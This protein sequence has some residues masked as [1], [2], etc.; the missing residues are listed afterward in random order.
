[1]KTRLYL[2]DKFGD[3]ATKEFE[4]ELD[5]SVQFAI[6]KQ[7]ED[8]SNPTLIINDWSKT[9][10]I[11]FTKHNNEVF[12]YIYKAD[13]IVE[14]DAPIGTFNFDASKKVQ[15]RLTHNENIVMTGYMK[16]LSVEQ[17]SSVSG[18]YNVTLNGEMGRIFQEMKKLTFDN[19]EVPIDIHITGDVLTIQDDG[20]DAENQHLLKI[21][22]TVEEKIISPNT[23]IRLHGADILYIIKW[24]ETNYTTAFN[25]QTSIIKIWANEDL[26]LTD[27]TTWKSEYPLNPLDQFSIQENK[28]RPKFYR[29]MKGRSGFE[30][31]FTTNKIEGATQI[32]YDG[33]LK[34]TIPDGD[35]Y[36]WY[37]FTIETDIIDIPLQ[38]RLNGA[39]QYFQIKNNNI[40]VF[41]KNDETL[42]FPNDILASIDILDSPLYYS[43]SSD[44]KYYSTFDTNE[45]I[46]RLKRNNDYRLD[47]IS[48]DNLSK[49][50]KSRYYHYYIDGEKYL[51]QYLNADFVEKCMSEGEVKMD[52]DA[53]MQVTDIFGFTLNNAFN[54]NF[55]YKSAIKDGYIQKLSEI[56]NNSPNKPVEA[57][58][59]TIIGNGITPLG[60][61]QQFRSYQQLPF[62]YFDKLFQIFKLESERILVDEGWKFDLDSD[63]FTTRNPFYFQYAFML[64]PFGTSKDRE[65]TELKTYEVKETIDIYIAPITVTDAIPDD[66]YK[67]DHFNVS[68]KKIY[69]TKHNIY[70]T[71]DLY[72]DF[73][74]LY[75]DVPD[76]LEIRDVL[77]QCIPVTIRVRNKNNEY[78]ESLDVKY[79]CVPK[80]YSDNDFIYTRHQ[81]CQRYDVGNE[82]KYIRGNYDLSERSIHKHQVNNLNELEPYEWTKYGTGFDAV[83]RIR[84]DIEL[85]NVETIFTSEVFNTDGV[86]ELNKQLKQYDVVFSGQYLENSFRN[87]SFNNVVIGGSPIG[88]AIRPIPLPYYT[89]K[90]QSRL[91]FEIFRNKN[92]NTFVT[93]NDF[94]NNEY[95][96]FNV[97][98][99]YCKMFRILIDVDYIQK[100]IK[101]MPTYKFFQSGKIIDWSGKVD[102]SK[103]WKLQPVIIDSNKLLFNYD[104]AKTSLGQKY[105]S[106][107]GYNSG[108]KI[109]NTDYAFNNDTKKLFGGLKVSMTYTDT[110]IRWSD[111]LPDEGSGKI[112]Y[113][114]TDL[115]MVYN[116]DKDSKAL[117]CFGQYF[118]AHDYIEFKDNAYLTDDTII[119]LKSGIYTY[120]LD[121]YKSKQLYKYHWLNILYNDFYNDWI[122]CN[123]F[124]IPAICYNA[125]DK[126]N[127][128]SQ[129][130]LYNYDS[131]I[132]GLY[133]IIWKDYI[134]D[135]YSNK[136]KLITTYIR[137]NN[138]DMS[139]F[140]F[141]NFITIENQLYLVNK[142]YDYDISSNEST[143]VDLITIGNIDN[144]KKTPKYII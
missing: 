18:H 68:G 134:N 113:N 105:K 96:L 137:F 54:D 140:S 4:V 73:N 109:I 89:I 12:G 26:I 91:I 126:T 72:E 122:Y 87:I 63:W 59:D 44:Y 10:A 8:L 119:E 138:T 128:A 41:E 108:E 35:F 78:I 57:D 11:P 106:E 64:E 21:S 100:K 90:P 7:F 111:L 5:N 93:L 33:I 79:L 127:D 66:F 115:M 58:G 24:E 83:A 135:R 30:F 13:R 124:N 67:G 76:N 84:L 110:F 9:V 25:N 131:S 14:T 1:M 74:Y 117:S 60:F 88:T 95:N 53:N 99:N 130:V 37:D 114:I 101:F 123:T 38:C 32:L 19:K 98:L 2:Y 104:D 143:K 34:C 133:D 65:D 80:S 136:T 52:I 62:I 82:D 15:F 36:N 121:D 42:V 28:I 116:K 70:A 139:N 107:V 49:I 120:N 125:F 94:W 97:I 3:E 47:T 55:D 118:F 69:K 27:G 29:E 6:T 43:L 16:F 46:T 22:T 20:V 45:K 129:W 56:I 144:Y 50:I 31:Y 102:Y 142:I 77:Y 23:E 51:K 112:V 81:W 141:A 48:Y 92:S 39:G 85:L 103:T 71:L 17:T 132:P 61:N 75:T 40:N 86:I